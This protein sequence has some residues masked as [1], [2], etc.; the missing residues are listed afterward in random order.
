MPP[1]CM[2]AEIS[3]HF[4]IPPLLLLLLPLPLL[5]IIEPSGTNFS[6][7]GPCFIIVVD[8]D[9]IVVIIVIVVI[10]RSV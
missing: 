1:G 7:C 2:N 8:I 9:I 5:L 10:I 3:N 6:V 4:T